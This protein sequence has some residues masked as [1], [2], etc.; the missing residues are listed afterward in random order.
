MP[1]EGNLGK[2]VFVV[3]WT[4]FT[5]PF[6][7]QGFQPRSF[8]NHSFDISL[9]SGLK[10]A[11][12]V[13][14]RHQEFHLLAFDTGRKG[15]KREKY[16]MEIKASPWQIDW[17][18]E[19][20]AQWREGSSL[21]LSALVE[22]L[23]GI[24]ILSGEEF[25]GFFHHQNLQSI[26]H[27]GNRPVETIGRRLCRKDYIL[28]CYLGA[29]GFDEENRSENGMPSGAE[30]MRHLLQGSVFLWDIT[31]LFETFMRLD[32]YSLFK[33]AQY[34]AASHVSVRTTH[35]TL[36]GPLHLCNVSCEQITGL[37]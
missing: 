13:Q 18:A 1:K 9:R 32:H 25:P 19:T 20:L 27:N 5:Q 14:V 26:P 11:A 7:H 22:V 36:P 10:I 16:F 12:A 24:P 8:G 37:P 21:L 33:C 3:I 2:W 6:K 4:S 23:P 15:S 30:D 31:V 34:C 17:L 29:A 28:C 35:G